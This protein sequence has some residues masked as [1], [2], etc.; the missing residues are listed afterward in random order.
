M[1]DEVEEDEDEDAPR[2]SYGTIAVEV[3]DGSVAMGS[4][5]TDTCLWGKS[6]SCRR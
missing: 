1:V 4:V 6:E 3:D 5:R 2:G